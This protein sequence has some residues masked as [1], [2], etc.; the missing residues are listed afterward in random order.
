M[1]LRVGSEEL[2]DGWAGRWLSNKYVLD[3]NQATLMEKGWIWEAGSDDINV[4][5][6]FP[7]SRDP[8][9]TGRQLFVPRHQL[10]AERATKEEKMEKKRATQN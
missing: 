4:S 1:L 10:E 8:I 6:L 3:S 7:G 9:R 2:R 5:R